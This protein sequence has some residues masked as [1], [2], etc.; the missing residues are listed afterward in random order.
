MMSN[1]VLQQANNQQSK[2]LSQGQLNTSA[3]AFKMSPRDI[4]VPPTIDENVAITEATLPPLPPLT[5]VSL[6][7][8]PSNRSVPQPLTPSPTPT[9]NSA[10][11]DMPSPVPVYAPSSVY[12]PQI[13]G[14]A[15]YHF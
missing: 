13:L 7:P 1:Q 14:P 2:P 10:C 6:S 4:S 9:T 8:S 5:S 12:L 11:N 3:P 15:N